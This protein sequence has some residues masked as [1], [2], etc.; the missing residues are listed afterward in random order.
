MH[1]KKKKKKESVSD[2]HRCLIE[3][4]K[5]LFKNAIIH[6]NTMAHVAFHK[7]ECENL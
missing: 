6:K 2:G 3:N 7:A 4:Q 1:A 5:G